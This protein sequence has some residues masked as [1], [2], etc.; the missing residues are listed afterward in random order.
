MYLPG[1]DKNQFPGQNEEKRAFKP[2]FF[3]DFERLRLNPIQFPLF[4][5]RGAEIF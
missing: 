3:L 2:L 1:I 4:P 5:Y